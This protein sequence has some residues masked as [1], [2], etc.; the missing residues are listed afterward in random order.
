MLLGLS[1]ISGQITKIS[2]S[3]SVD[4]RA[5]WTAGGARLRGPGAKGCSEWG[6]GGWDRPPLTNQAKGSESLMA[7]AETAPLEARSHAAPASPTAVQQ[8]QADI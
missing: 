3:D 2:G 5:R 6:E 4:V 7:T 8:N 1:I